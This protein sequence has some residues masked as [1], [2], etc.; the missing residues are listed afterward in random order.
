MA[1]EE[2]SQDKPRQ[3]GVSKSRTII[4][5][6]VGLA[7]VVVVAVFVKTLMFPESGA[8]VE[9]SGT[10]NGGGVS[11]M[12]PGEV[13]QIWEILTNLAKP[14]Q[15]I[16]I[17]VKVAVELDAMA[18]SKEARELSKELNARKIEF[19]QVVEE[20]LQSRTRDDL[21]SETGREGTRQEILRKI[22]ARLQAGKLRKVLTTDMLFS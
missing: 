2:E 19:K 22:N 1:V 14:D 12:E 7:F 8:I 11:V 21:S 16:Y 6:C 5:A 3:G 9:G 4:L 17:S 13:L 15:D 20:V 18:G 10:G